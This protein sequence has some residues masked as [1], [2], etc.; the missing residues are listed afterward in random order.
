MRLR[1]LTPRSV[2]AVF[3]A[4]RSPKG[5]PISKSLPDDLL[6]DCRVCASRVALLDELPR[7]GVVIEL[8]T[9][10]GDFARHILA[11]C[12]PRELHIVDIDYS[13]FDGSGLNDP[14]IKRH[15]GFTHEVIATF[16]DR[17]FDWV[18]VDADH[19]YDG[20]IRDARAAAPKIKPGGFMVF[21]DFAHIDP[22]LGRYGVHRA[23]VDF[24]IEAKWPFRYF[25]Y[26]VAGMYD[27][28]LQRPT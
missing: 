15:D 10:K 22:G 21:N 20:T 5:F 13:Q 12:R 23:V 6:R 27:V 16:A 4:V 2:R 18:Y 24:A 25:A 11:R 14:R 28:A 26:E 3:R 9:Y 7:D 1:A 8:G 17:T 19:S